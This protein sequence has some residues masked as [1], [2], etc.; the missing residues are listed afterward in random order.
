[1]LAIAVQVSDADRLS[2]SPQMTCSRCNAEYCFLCGGF[3]FGGAHFAGWNLFG[4]PNMK[5]IDAAANSRN[6]WRRNLFRY[7]VA[8]P[9]MLLGFVLAVSLIL[10]VE[11]LWL[12][13]FL[14]LIPVWLLL[15]GGVRATT[16]KHSWTRTKWEKRIGYAA[17]WGLKLV[18]AF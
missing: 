1:M 6:T 2:V 13:W 17:F 9:V 15:L 16:T 4:C 5:S 12:G 14:A 18:Q 7:F 11:S 8:A 3:Y 10:A